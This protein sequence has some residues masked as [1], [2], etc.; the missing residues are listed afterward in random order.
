M[1]FLMIAF[2]DKKELAEKRES[3]I[4]RNVDVACRWLF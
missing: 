2:A 1:D 3:N 4:S